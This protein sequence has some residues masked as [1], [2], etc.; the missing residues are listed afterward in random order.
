MQIITTT[1]AE[2]IS[3]RR[4]PAKIY[5]PLP[6]SETVQICQ[7]DRIETD[8]GN[9]DL[10][11]A[12]VRSIVTL[13]QGEINEINFLA[14]QA[15]RL[16][17]PP[18]DYDHA[19]IILSPEQRQYQ[20]Q[21]GRQPLLL[22]AATV[23]RLHDEHPEYATQHVDHPRIQPQRTQLI[24]PIAEHMA[25]VEEDIAVFENIA[26][27]NISQPSRNRLNEVAHDSGIVSLNTSQTSEQPVV[28]NRSHMP[29]IEQTDEPRAESL[30]EDDYHRK[31]IR[32]L[33]LLRQVDNDP[34]VNIQPIHQQPIEIFE[35]ITTIPPA[36]IP[37]ERTRLT[38]T[39]RFDQLQT[40]EHTDVP[41]IYESTGRDTTHRIP[42]REQLRSS[43]IDQD[44]QT[45]HRAEENRIQW[46]QRTPIDQ[47][48]ITE[49]RSEHTQPL[50]QDTS[51]QRETLQPRETT[52]DSLER[53]R[54]PN[55][56]IIYGYGK[57]LSYCLFFSPAFV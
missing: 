6:E 52:P 42:Q 33:D 51:D 13:N 35:H 25:K 50:I 57:Y 56:S 26:P 20:H 1:E 17:L 18:H 23:D 48:Q 55:K 31:R 39:H 12:N 14:Q 3:A 21:I 54:Q 4:P 30:H 8:S 41:V 22:A 19:M 7:A 9:Y 2:I 37:S 36:E 53:S 47:Y 38:D 29:R 11:M 5:T 45:T 40:T 44:N 43:E 28:L 32:A 24:D 34:N 16:Q 15:Q 27:A 10:S 46:G 49:I